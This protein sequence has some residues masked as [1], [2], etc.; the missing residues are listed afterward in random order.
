DWSGLAVPAV[1]AAPATASADGL[2]S[3]DDGGPRRQPELSETVTYAPELA[4]PTAD[5]ALLDDDDD[6]PLP[7]PRQLDPVMQ[8]T[9]R[10]ASL[11][12]NDGI[13]L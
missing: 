6:L 7:L 4:V 2:G 9:A 11:D 5:L 13:E 12:P 3:T 1:P 8:R 10:L